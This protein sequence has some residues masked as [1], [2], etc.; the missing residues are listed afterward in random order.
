[1]YTSADRMS[2]LVEERYEL[3]RV[4]SRF[5]IALGFGDKSI[6]CVCREQQLDVNTFLAVVNMGESGSSPSIERPYI[7][8]TF[9]LLSDKIFNNPCKL[10][11]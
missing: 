3:L 11:D 10:P 8:S 5:N 4:L 2:E 6:E 7:Y 1:M 9:T